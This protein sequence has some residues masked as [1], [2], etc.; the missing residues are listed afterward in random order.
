MFIIQLRYRRFLHNSTEDKTTNILY[1]VRNLMKSVKLHIYW[2]KK[3]KKNYLN[4]DRWN[5]SNHIC[6]NDCQF[7]EYWES[8]SMLI[9]NLQGIQCVVPRYQGLGCS[10]DSP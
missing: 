8:P 4:C 3:K 1:L 6:F 9:T 10:N 5:T 2:F 7:H